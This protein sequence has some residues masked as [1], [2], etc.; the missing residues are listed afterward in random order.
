MKVV[1]GVTDMV[2]FPI[3]ETDKIMDALEQAEKSGDLKSLQWCARFLRWLWDEG[4]VIGVDDYCYSEGL[5][6][7]FGVDDYC[8]SEGL[9][10]KLWD[11]LL[12]SD[13]P[14]EGIAEIINRKDKPKPP[15]NKDAEE[16][17]DTLKSFFEDNLGG[18]GFNA[19]IEKL[20][21]LKQAVKKTEAA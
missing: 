19:V 6:N 1:S 14:P 2:E 15:G 21:A 16:A 9:F 4:D 13:P 3:E 20:D 7:K 8:Y 17:I 11:S 5:F 10:N 12:K 18:K